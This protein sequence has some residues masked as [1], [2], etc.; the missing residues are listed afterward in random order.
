MNGTFVCRENVV[1][2]IKS[3]SLHIVTFSID[4][5]HFP[6]ASAFLF[7]LKGVLYNADI[8]CPIWV[9]LNWRRRDE[10]LGTRQSLELEN[11]V[12]RAK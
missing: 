10:N 8:A 12:I 5:C 9:Y 7:A 4:V 11:C 6:Y 3:S 1:C 2:N